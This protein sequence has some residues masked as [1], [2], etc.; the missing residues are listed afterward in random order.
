MISAEEARELTQQHSVRMLGNIRE[1]K[2]AVRVLASEFVNTYVSSDIERQA[3]KYGENKTYFTSDEIKTFLR[4]K[5]FRFY[6]NRDWSQG[7][8]LSA[9]HHLEFGIGEQVNEQFP[10]PVDI[11]FE[12]IK[13]QLEDVGFQASAVPKLET[14][15]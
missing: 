2:E 3:C 14:L 15:W 11:I 12:E 10:H 9:R 1:F 6:M 5:G 7:W 13:E 4:K 8:G